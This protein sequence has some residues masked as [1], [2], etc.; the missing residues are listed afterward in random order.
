MVMNLNETNPTLCSVFPRETC[1]LLTVFL[2]KGRKHTHTPGCDVTEGWSLH[3][4]VGGTYS[5]QE[6]QTLPSVNRAGLGS[7]SCYCS[8]CE[9]M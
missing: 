8:V 3:C 7:A 9:I 5:S 2:H 4:L 6:E 1:S